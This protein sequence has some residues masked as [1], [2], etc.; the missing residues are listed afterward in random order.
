ME[1][2]A[3]QWGLLPVQSPAGGCEEVAELRFSA[4]VAAAGE[5]EHFEVEQNLPW[6][7]IISG[8]NSHRCPPP[9][10]PPALTPWRQ[11]FRILT[12]PPV[13]PIVNDVLHDVGVRPGGNGG[14]HIPTYERAAIHHWCERSGLRAFD[15][16]R[17][18][19]ERAFQVWVALKNRGE[20]ESVPT[21][22]IDY[23]MDARE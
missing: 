18:F 20:Q 2:P 4:L 14:K 17:H 5:D 21:A 10:V 1:A 19:I 12:Q 16:G 8:L 6:P 11:F 3:R 9:V 22:N 15:D 7:E 13:G 23:R